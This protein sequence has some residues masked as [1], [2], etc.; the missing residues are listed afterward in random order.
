LSGAIYAGIAFYAIAAILFLCVAT[1]PEKEAPRF[2]YLL[3]RVPRLE[4][5]RGH[6]FRG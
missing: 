6:L 5:F 3:N 4:P 2:I 1:T